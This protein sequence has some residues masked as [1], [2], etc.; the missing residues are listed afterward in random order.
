MP[1]QSAR[2]LQPVSQQFHPVPLPV[3]ADLKKPFIVAD[4]ALDE[5][6]GEVFF[7]SDICVFGHYS[8]VSHPVCRLVHGKSRRGLCSLRNNVF[9]E[10]CPA[11]TRKEDIITVKLKTVVYTAIFGGYEGLLPQRSFPGVDYVCFSDAP[12]RAKPWTVRYV[13][14]PESDPTRCARKYKIL[15][16]HYFPEYERSI[17]MDGNYLFVG[18]IDDLMEKTLRNHNMAYFDHRSS[19]AD[20]R[21]CVYEEYASIIELGRASGSFKDDPVVMRKQVERYRAE[22]YPAHNGLIFSSVLIRR[23]HAEDVVATMERW[24][25]E[26]SQGSKRDQLSFN[27][28]AWKESLTATVISENVR[29]NRWFFQVG[30]H[31][32]SYR[33]K[34][35]RYR[36]KRLFG[37]LRH[38]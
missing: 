14:P 8:Q 31:R 15:P 3:D 12:V 7:P 20:S 36:L 25:R 34:L 27:Y 33:M 18:D 22:G 23:H 13:P 19:V 6:K 21:D 1:L 29:D 2:P 4:I 28:A 17:W 38:R 10:T 30:I 5:V 11:P 35:L 16:H 24:W 32:K 37:L 26:L 9:S